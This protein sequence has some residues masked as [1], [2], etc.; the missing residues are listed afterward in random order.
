MASGDVILSVEENG[1]Q[2]SG[3][4]N[5]KWNATLY[6]TVPNPV[7]PYPVGNT[8]V[9]FVITGTNAPRQ[10]DM[11]DDAKKYKIVITEV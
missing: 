8:S 4:E 10:Q 9:V 1:V 5:G 6:G 3:T 7:P 11:F 2:A